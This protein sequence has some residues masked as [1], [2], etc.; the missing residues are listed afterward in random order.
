ME[1]N[2]H[3]DVPASLFFFFFF[4]ND[5][6]YIDF[7]NKLYKLEQRPIRSFTIVSFDTENLDIPHLALMK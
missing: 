7:K 2:K 4:G 5:R 3:G 6:K 1:I